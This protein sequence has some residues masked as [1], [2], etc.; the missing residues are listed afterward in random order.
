MKLFE[1]LNL[2]VPDMLFLYTVL[3]AL[4][5]P[6]FVL[7]STMVEKKQFQIFI[8]MMNEGLGKTE[9]EKDYEQQ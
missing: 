2:I 7:F 8:T 4:F 9:K 5:F 3:S 1:I 6:R